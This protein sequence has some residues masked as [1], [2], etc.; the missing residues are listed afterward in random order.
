[1]PPR[2]GTGFRSHREYDSCRFESFV[3]LL[4]KEGVLGG[5]P[6]FPINW[7]AVILNIHG[8]RRSVR[9]YIKQSR[10]NLL[11]PASANEK[12]REAGRRRDTSGDDKG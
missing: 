7:N 3:R 5:E 1:M 4:V 8:P 2:L 11:R 6:G 10:S 12:G 9:S